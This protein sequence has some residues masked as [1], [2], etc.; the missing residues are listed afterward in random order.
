[1]RLPIH[2]ICLI[3]FLCFINT[4]NQAQN[5][6]SD[7]LNQILSKHPPS[8]QMDTLLQLSLKF[9]EV[10]LTKSLAIVKKGNILARQ[11]EKMDYV[12]KFNVQTGE[13]Y[14]MMGNYDTAHLYLDKAIAIYHK[15]G[16][17]NDLAASLKMKSF[18]YQNQG[19]F[20]QT[21]EILL[22][23]LN[24][25]EKRSDKKGIAEIY[26][27]LSDLFYF[28][29]QYAKGLAHGEKAIILYQELGDERGLS[30]AYQ[31]TA[32]NYLKL[33]KYDIALDLM[34]KALDLKKEQ[35]THL[36]DLS[37]LINAR[38]NVLKYMERYD[39]ALKDYYK[40]LTMVKRMEHQGGISAVTA[41]IAD[42]Y[43]RIGNYAAALPLKLE[44]IR[45]AEA[46]G[47]LANHLENIGHLSEIYKNLGDYKEALFYQEKQY[48]IRDSLF[49]LE[50]EKVISEL[51]TKYETTKKEELIAS[52]NQLLLQRQ[53]IQ[54]FSWGFVALLA[55][56]LFLVYRNFRN[57][58]KS[59]HLL[60]ST[61]AQLALKN[62]ENELLLKEIHHRVK[63]NLQVISSLLSFQSRSV[64]EKNVKSALL[65]SQSRVKSMSLIH[66]KLYK[67]ANLASIEMKAYLTTLTDSLIDAY[68]ENELE[69]E[70][71][72]NMHP[73]ELDVDYA[74][75][76]GLI[77]N[78]LLTNSLKHAFSG[79]KTGI[80][81]IELQREM[82]EFILNIKDNGIGKTEKL[83]PDLTSGFG[84]ELVEM[85]TEQLRG[86]LIQFIKDGYQTQIRFPYI[87]VL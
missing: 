20:E 50:K 55:I 58:Q 51:Q 80:I 74:I 12:A 87:K 25:Y 47:F 32:D 76:L 22:T 63:N 67:G 84:S 77:A 17:Q 23:A 61:N 9:S 62:K 86:K 15:I 53:R 68:I 82:N 34:N 27:G 4:F 24:I 2:N 13:I 18:V 79:R 38:G 31:Y 44:G 5:P 6:F 29:E 70:V 64:K 16:P 69:V 1:M 81:E 85:L 37:S 49:S 35:K 39:E 72:L 30:E 54:N 52:Q 56:M 21:H 14:Q 3:Y 60:T 10:D 83:L 48:A 7:S 42:V 78:E 41:N 59:N 40:S 8:D 33:E 57:K 71:K 73:V 65:D 45:I 43:M 75:P 36:I 19:K 28:Q 26:V 11:L 66:Q 46:N